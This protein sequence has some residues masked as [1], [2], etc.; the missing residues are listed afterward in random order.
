MLWQ[1]SNWSKPGLGNILE[2]FWLVKA[3]KGVRK[4]I[5]DGLSWTDTLHGRVGCLCSVPQPWVPLYS[6]IQPAWK[7]GHMWP[8]LA[9][10]QHSSALTTPG[11]THQCAVWHLW[12]PALFSQTWTS[13]IGSKVSEQNDGRKDSAVLQ[14][15][16]F[17]SIWGHPRE[18]TKSLSKL[19]KGNWKPKPHGFLRERT[20]GH[21]GKESI[22][23]YVIYIRRDWG[24]QW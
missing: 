7:R 6:M 23:G 18:L 21:P 16:F 22:S 13:D 24:S 14:V 8:V 10:N 17:S 5:R 9:G 2:T 12:E 19:G 1:P 11:I 15:T 20:S 3:Q 4:V